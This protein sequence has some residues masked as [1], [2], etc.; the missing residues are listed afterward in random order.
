VAIAY[1]LTMPAAPGFRASRFGL[2][3]NVALFASPLSGVE[4]ALERPGARWMAEYTL[5]PMTRAQ[6]AGWV[7]FLAA[8]RGRV[9][10]FKGF[11]PDARVPR[12]AATG[13]ARVKG[14]GQ[15]GTTLLTDGWTA[16][17]AGILKAGDYFTLT[18]PET[19]LYMVV[20]DA[21]SDGAGEATLE[22]EP[23]LRASP[24]DD[25]LLTTGNPYALFRLAGDEVGWDADHVGR[26]G[27]AF[28]ATEAL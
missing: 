4:Q 18:Q 25:A 7:A 21:A 24:T 19:R 6:A 9:G 23:G 22:I 11:D 16:S 13:T 27:L 10:T 20:G 26:F 14:A 5:P 2:A 3:R 28:A 12:G 1:P 8:L 15:T 17:V